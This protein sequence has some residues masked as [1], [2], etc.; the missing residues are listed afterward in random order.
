[1]RKLFHFLFIVQ[2]ITYK[3]KKTMLPLF[4]TT[5]SCIVKSFGS[6]IS[7]K[8]NQI[9]S[10]HWYSLD[11]RLCAWNIRTSLSMLR[12]RRLHN[13]NKMKKYLIYSKTR[14]FLG[15]IDKN[16][17]VIESFMTL[18]L[19]GSELSLQKFQNRASID[20]K[21]DALNKMHSVLGKIILFEWYIFLNLIFFSKLDLHP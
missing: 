21:S 4:L 13:W 10:Q 9:L 12:A 6:H 7:N 19:F 2:Q 3:I 17:S 20:E 5:S 8:N 18:Y 11:C 16:S 15:V 1:M 14:Y